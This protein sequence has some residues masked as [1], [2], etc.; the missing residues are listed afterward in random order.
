MFRII[1][2]ISL[3]TKEYQFCNK[4]LFFKCTNG[5]FFINIKEVIK[6]FSSN[7]NTH[8]LPHLTK[9][10]F[11][12]KTVFRIEN[13]LSLKLLILNHKTLNLKIF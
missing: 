8:F 2:F 13:I 1:H 10:M 9:F 7:Y 5:I 4:I 12:N 11:I 6:Y 3:F